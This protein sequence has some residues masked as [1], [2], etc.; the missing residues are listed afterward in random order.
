VLLIITRC[1]VFDAGPA[2]FLPLGTLL[3][4]CANWTYRVVGARALRA[5]YSRA[6]FL[7]YADAV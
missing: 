6:H 2:N 3:F 5:R 4:F 1:L 7:L